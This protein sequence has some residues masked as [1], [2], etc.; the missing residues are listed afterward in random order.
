MVKLTSGTHRRVVATTLGWLGLVLVAC[1]SSA[2][3]N[4]VADTWTWNGTDW[5]Q[6]H[7]AHS[8]PPRVWPAVGFDPATGKILLFGGHGDQVF[9]DT[10]TWDGHDWT[11]EHP[12][13]SPPPLSGSFDVVTDETNQAV[14]L[15][16]TPGP[17]LGSWPPSNDSDIWRWK[18]GQ[19][20]KVG[21]QPGIG[22]P[23]GIG[24]DR[25]SGH[26]LGLFRTWTTT[27]T[28]ICQSRVWTGSAFE[29]LG[30]GNPT[31]MEICGGLPFTDSQSGHLVVMSGR[32]CNES[33]YSWSGKD[34]VPGI[35]LA[36]PA[37]ASTT[38]LT[39]PSWYP[40][41]EQ[42]TLVTPRQVVAFGAYSCQSRPKSDGADWTDDT[43][44]W[45]AGDR[46]WMVAKP[47]HHPPFRANPAMSLDVARGQVVLF[48]GSQSYGCLINL[49]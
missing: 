4:Y 5:H 27:T 24:Y 43:L 13:L 36:P 14:L 45:N 7:P 28:S 17:S 46:R 15:V 39:D 1:G 25:E 20:V 8:P 30:D 9:T 10:W 2:G 21:S 44:V 16:M 12:S 41:I 37:K 22:S 3:P 26:V 11:E 49:P 31:A 48:G 23:A 18:G 32:C 42:A 33:L 19:W 38:L 6:E 47:A 29:L 35:T 34:W 40:D